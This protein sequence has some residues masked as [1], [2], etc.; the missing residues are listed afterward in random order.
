MNRISCML[1]AVLLVLSI[2]SL[3]IAFDDR[4]EGRDRRGHKPPGVALEACSE[5]E[6]AEECNFEGRRGEELTGTCEA[7]EGQLACVPEGRR[8]ARPAGRPR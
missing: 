7:I 6:E 5:A 3:A 1:G 2:S 8:R 4:E